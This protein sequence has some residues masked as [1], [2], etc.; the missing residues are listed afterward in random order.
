MVLGA[1]ASL[2][3]WPVDAPGLLTCS[4]QACLHPTWPLQNAPHT[5]QGQTMY[6]PKAGHPWMDSQSLPP[7]A[8]RAGP[9]SLPLSVAAP[10][11]PGSSRHPLGLQMPRQPYPSSQGVEE[12]PHTGGSGGLRQAQRPARH[13]SL[14]A[15]HCRLVFTAKLQSHPVSDWAVKVVCTPVNPHSRG[16]APPLI[17]AHFGSR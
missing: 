9:F 4:Q 6:P 5:L 11:G 7:Y 16:C 14:Y 13:R 12:P 17:W 3:H 15:L 1:G 8:Q 10:G 2:P